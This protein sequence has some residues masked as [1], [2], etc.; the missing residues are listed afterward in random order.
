MP[1]ASVRNRL[2]SP[3]RDS[4]DDPECVRVVVVRPGDDVEDHA[5]SR[6]NQCDAER[7]PEGVNREITVRDVVRGQQHQSVDYEDEQESGEQHQREAQSRNERWEHGVEDRDHERRYQRTPEIAR[8]GA[9]HDP[10]SGQ[11]RRRGEKPRNE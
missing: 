2:S 5:D 7:R 8:R 6:C 4:L 9:G 10:G 1:G 11:E 3:A